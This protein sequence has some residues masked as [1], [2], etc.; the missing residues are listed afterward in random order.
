MRQTLAL[1]AKRWTVVA[2]NR[3]PFS[4][5]RYPEQQ[6]PSTIPR[7]YFSQKIDETSSNKVIYQWYEGVENLGGYR[8][9]RYH[10]THI[11]QLYSNERYEIVH[12]LGFG[13]NSTVVSRHLHQRRAQHVI[14]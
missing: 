4:S 9:G 11:G 12:K 2:P 10:P 8:P 13:S 5:H 7:F 14:L 6:L 3:V 1:S